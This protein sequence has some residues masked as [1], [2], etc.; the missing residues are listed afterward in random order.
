MAKAFTV[1]AGRLESVTLLETDDWLAAERAA[2]VT[3]AKSAWDRFGY[4]RIVGTHPTHDFEGQGNCTRCGSPQGGCYKSHAPC[5]FEFEHALYHYMK[6][7]GCTTPDGTYVPPPG[8]GTM[9]SSS[10]R[11]IG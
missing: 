5:G 4:V 7:A 9:G 10:S 3:F 6:E 11:R 1:V 2:S 8:E